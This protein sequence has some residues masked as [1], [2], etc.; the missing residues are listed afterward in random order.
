MQALLQNWLPPLCQILDGVTH[1]TVWTGP[2]GE[3]HFDQI[4]HWPDKGRGTAAITRVARASLRSRKPVVKTRHTEGENTGEPRDTLACPIFLGDQLAGVVGVELTHR[5]QTLQ[6]QALEQLQT[7]VMWLGAMLRLRRSAATDQLAN[8]V[9]LVAAGLENDRFKVAVT[10]VANEL[11]T[12]FGCHRVSIGFRRLGS[13]QVAAI[14]HSTQ[15][16]RRTHLTRAIRDAMT[17]A[18]DQGET[19]V[20]PPLSDNELQVTLFHK[21]LA[22]IQP[23]TALCSVP[24]V[25]NGRA[26]GA[27]LL[28]REA[29]K[30]FDP[31]T[32]AHCEQVG[33]LLGPVLETRRSDERPLVFKGVEAVGRS[34]AKLFGP[35]HLALKLGT[36]LVTA[37]SL[38]AIV[39]PG[40]FRISSDTELEA[41][42]CRSVVAPQEGYIASAHVRAGDR[43]QRG[44]LLA[45]LDDR[46][47]LQE[48]R[49]WQSQS[50]QLHKEYHKALAAGDRAEV[51]ILKARRAQAEAQ[52]MLVTQQL[53]RIHLKAPLSGMVVSGDLTQ[54]LGAP[55]ERGE[56]LYEVAPTNDFRVVLRVDDR[57]IGFMAAG[58]RGT[59]KLTGIPDRGLAITI[60][61]LT[62]VAASEAGRT[63]FRVEALLEEESDLMRPGMAGI[64]K[65]EVGRE[66][67]WWIWT[68]RLLDWTRIFLWNRLP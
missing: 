34:L 11:T 51:A 59:L 57:D 67:L 33:L 24:L 32:V 5:S 38:V 3:G 6:R 17:E 64:A 65:V 21:Q 25:R 41:S 19:I 30:T 61:R 22:Q 46:D 49:K 63:Y 2:P 27:I 28:E 1:A 7:G 29:G 39:A 54:S 42:I 47:L 56:V 8:L 44:Q 15:V 43:V 58:Q 10:E 62:P 53:E 26:V 35:R 16:H 20:Y 60:D 66:K 31:E 45:S 23:G 4:T 18:M 9:D 48:R 12:R 13:L 52:L 37:V 55:V 14:S 40:T 68:R 50:N 36:F